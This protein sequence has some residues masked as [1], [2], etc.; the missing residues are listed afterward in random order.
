MRRPGFT[1]LEML[2]ATAL[3]AILMVGVLGLITDIGSS[4]LAAAESEEPGRSPTAALE[5]WAAL[6]RED[7][8]HAREVDLSQ[9]NELRLVGTHALDSARREATHRPVEVVYRME[10][11]DGRSVLVREQAALDV[12][13][14]RNVQRDLVCG[15]VDRFDLGLRIVEVDRY[16]ATSGDIAASGHETSPAGGPDVGSVAPSAAPRP[17]DNREPEEHAHAEPDGMTDRRPD[18]FRRFSSDSVHRWTILSKQR[19]GAAL[20]P[21]T[22]P[23]P[24]GSGRG[25]SRVGIDSDPRPTNHDD[26]ANKAEPKALRAVWRLR[27]WSDSAEQPSLDRVV[28]IQGVSSR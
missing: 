8:E 1:L 10:E 11:I 12:A 2:L 3:A 13:T 25:Q 18:V 21:G 23:G 9:P 22:G 16:G 27:A 15:G 20:G 6:L 4:Q 5:A 17:G 26:S 7:L 28:L 19:G 24:A 14:N